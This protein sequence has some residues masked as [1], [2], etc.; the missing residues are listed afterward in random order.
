MSQP[1]VSAA[2]IVRD[3]ADHLRRCLASIVDWVDQ[4][5]V[6][7]TG[8]VDDSV[9]VARQFGAT[10]GTFPWTGDFAAARN[11]ALDLSIGRWLLYIDAD[12]IVDPVD[13]TAVHA[14][15]RDH[16]A[17]IALRV[18]FRSRPAFSPYREFRLWKHRPDIRFV[19][20][21]HETPV[22]D[23]RRISADEGLSVDDS[24]LVRLTHYG[25]EGDQTKKHRRNLPMLEQ[26]V[27]EFP[28]RCYLWNHLG[29]VREALGDH[30]GA[31]QAWQTGID[32]IR[33]RGIA[34]RTDVLCY[35]G[36]GLH[37]SANGHDV[38]PLCR[39]LASIAPWYRTRHWMSA[40]NHR[41]HG[42]FAESIEPL[43]VLIDLGADACDDSL[44]YNNSMFTDWAWDALS[45]SYLQLGDVAAAAAV[46]REASA[47]FPDRLDY[48]T[49]AAAL[50]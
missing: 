44:S 18:W 32:L 2:I 5:V 47:Y 19:G 25:Y 21:I 24:A 3:E 38:Q 30:A 12:E 39:E 9:D 26:R 42:R 48:R 43:R 37:L 49:K 8:S 28:N 10:L 31:I 16:E 46:F 1:L 41:R 7:D 17:S 11:H 34:D 14:E 29:N 4:I 45:D 40:L 23:I 15:L 13:R 33:R 36:L 50:G 20:R 35:A 22:P 6:V 27:V